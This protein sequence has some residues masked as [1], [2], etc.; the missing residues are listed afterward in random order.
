MACLLGRKYRSSQPF[1]KRY[2]RF[3]NIAKLAELERQLSFH[4]PKPDAIHWDEKI[5]QAF[6]ITV[7]IQFKD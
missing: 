7:G 5:Q 2:I 6:F 1:G 4:A 3:R